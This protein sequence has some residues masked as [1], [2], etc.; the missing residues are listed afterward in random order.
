MKGPAFSTL[1]CPAW[2]LEQALINTVIPP[3]RDIDSCRV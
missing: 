2:T 3:N 1:A